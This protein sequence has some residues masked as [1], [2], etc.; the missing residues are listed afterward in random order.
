MPKGRRGTV[1]R[2][3]DAIFYKA[4]TGKSWPEVIKDTGA[5]IQASKHFNAWISD[6]SWTRVNAALSDVEQVPL[7]ELQLLPPMIIEGR[8]DPSAMLS[9]EGL[10][11]T[12]CR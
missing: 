1:R 9:P 4:R 5:T 7:P 6:G 10:S 11:R 8:V 3:V 12:E 2:S